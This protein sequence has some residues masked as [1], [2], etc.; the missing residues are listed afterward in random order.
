VELG[1]HNVRVNCVAPGL[2]KTEFARALWEN[3]KIAESAAAA[4]PL[5]RLGEPDDIAGAVVFLGSP[6]A[7]YITGQNI[8]IDGG[9]TISSA[10]L[11]E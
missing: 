11:I 9:A 7:R 1:P 10:A 6:A 4:T 3:P 2:I 5:R 8:V